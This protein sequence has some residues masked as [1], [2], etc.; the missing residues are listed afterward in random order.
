MAASVPAAGS[1]GLASADVS[2]VA[3]PT[4]SSGWAAGT[5]GSGSAIWHTDSAGAS[6]QTQWRGSGKLISL[7]AADPGHAWA[8]EACSRSCGTHLL[9]THV[10]GTTDGGAAWRVLATLPKQ[11]VQVQ[12][13][14]ASLGLITV[15]GCLPGTS[16]T[17]NL[18]RCHGQVLI[19]RDGGTSWSRVLSGSLPVF[20]VADAHGQLWAAKPAAS[21]IVTF[22]TSGNDGKTWS[23]LGT[24]RDSIPLSGEVDVTLA[25]SGGQLAWASVFD[26]DSCAMHGCLTDLVGTGNGGRTW[27]Q[28]NLPDRYPDECGLATVELSVGQ[29][30]AAWIGAARNGA[31]CAPPL[32]LFYQSSGPGA[33]WRQL[34]PW[35]L[36]GITSMDAVNTQVAY[37]IGDEGALA[38][39][40]DG[41]QHWIQL[42]PAP[43]PAGELDVVSLGTVF[44]AQ[45]GI[46]AGAI[47]RANGT[48]GWTQ[49]AELPGVITQLDF[50]SSAR[51]VAVTDAPNSSAGYRLWTSTDGGASWTPGGALPKGKELIG[52]WV[53]ADGHG[54]LLTENGG[55]PW[56]PQTGGNPPVR[57]WVTS[58]W[59]AS[60][61]Q[62]GTIPLGRDTPSGP[63]SFAYANGTW[64]GWLAVL[65]TRYN[66][67][68]D[69][70]KVG[71]QGASGLSVLPGK[72]PT[73]NVQ[74]VGPN[75]G[76]A[77]TID[78]SGHTPVLTLKR[79][80]NGGRTWQRYTRT[81]SANPSAPLPLIGFSSAE[82]GWL[83]TGNS[84]LVTADGGRTWH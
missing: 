26:L 37:A 79:T 69:V 20:A 17:V 7:S 39:T 5:A 40:E 82:D 51:G 60:W 3:F 34:P 10:L 41:G 54:L 63:V 43:V 27:H 66:F 29:D 73:G 32:G 44:G 18:S 74:L 15:D 61:H 19:T 36:S 70:A 24:T 16:L 14:T 55:E 80:V 6:W 30:G 49:L 25:L 31:A 1:N 71:P 56:N 48:S 46:D 4:A 23:R 42:L 78:Y 33:G 81:L 13:A 21:G 68:I 58:N 45:D 77:W 50:P 62:A 65:D 35:Q 47:L 22:L 38:R 59:G 9:G 52:P 75:A 12:F 84:T 8:I 76:F 53:T 67:R 57:E 2:A 11:A 83:V 28:L 64:T 72:P